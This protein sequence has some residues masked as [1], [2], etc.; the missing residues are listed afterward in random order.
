M[1]SSLSNVIESIA[2]LDPKRIAIIHEFHEISYADLWS[3]IQRGEAW[4]HH[5]GLRR[6]HWVA[7]TVRDQYLHLVISLALIRV[8]CVQ[9]C[10][11]SFESVETNRRLAD[12][13]PL[14]WQIIE[15]F[16]PG[17]ASLPKV[18]IESISEVRKIS[19]P[20]SGA[21]IYFDDVCIVLTSSGTTGR[22]KLIPL[23][24][25]LLVNWLPRYGDLSFVLH[26]LVSIEHNI[27][28]RRFLGTLLWSGAI[29]T[30]SNGDLRDTVKLC[31]QYKVSKLFLST[32]H[33]CDILHHARNVHAVDQVIAGTEIYL[34]GSK[35]DFGLVDGLHHQLSKQV[36]VAYGTTESGIITR[37][38]YE[39]LLR[40]ENS[41]GYPLSGVN[42][43]IVDEKYNALPAGALG[44]IGIKSDACIKGYLFDEELSI[45]HFRDG[46]FYPG[47]VGNLTDDGM[48]IHR[49][50]ADDVIMLNSINI[51][52]AE[53]EKVAATYPGVAECVAFPIK[54]AVHGAI[55]ALAATSSGYLNTDALLAFCK[56][57]LGIRA[58]RKI[59]QVD[60]IPRTPEGKILRRELAET[61]GKRNQ[62]TQ[63]D[64]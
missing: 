60:K 18:A 64:T 36:L 31:Q 58:P 28:K 14:Q 20:K 50:R 59:Y 34:S 1:R 44:L 62:P 43:Q 53:I 15:G 42:I 51:F 8:G 21:S 41:V 5:Q 52:P 11:P 16:L 22:Q 7:L 13:L 19:L 4:I 9:V 23:D 35:V 30:S 46:W 45:K 55:P 56:K 12:R 57:S 29:L 24:E 49:G 3:D 38:T 27:G 10:L 6:R 26:Q 39:D 33:A 63:A 47:D 2:T 17:V 48:L 32:Y 61:V 54:S 37:T 25:R 40:N